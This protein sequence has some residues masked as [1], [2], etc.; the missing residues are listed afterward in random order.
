MPAA[1]LRSVAQPERQPQVVIVGAGFGGLSAARALCGKGADVTIV[2][3]QN[4]HLFQPLLYQVATAGLSPADIAAPIRSV[5]K[6]HKATR[7]LLDEVTGV[8]A[9][10][11]LVLLADGAPLPYDYLVLATG[12]THSYF[13]RDDWAGVAPGLK[14]IDD[15]TRLRRNI[16][17]ALEHAE[18]L[19]AGPARDRQLTFVLVGGGPTGV[20]MAGAIAELCR[21]TVTAD[22]R[23]IMTDQARVILVQAAP[24]L[25]PS[26]PENLSECAR[27][28]L[29]KLG[30]EVLTDARV[31]DIDAEGVS[32]DDMRIEAGTVIWCA[33]VKASPVAD[34][35][36]IAAD[37]TGRVTVGPDLS[38]PEFPNVF[39]IGDAAMVAQPD[40]RSVPGLA[41]AAK[42]MGEHVARVIAAL[43]AGTASPGAFRYKDWGNLATI[44]RKRAVADFGFARMRGTLAWLLW[45]VAHIF[46]L[47]G[48][49]N[50][51]IV[52]AN[53]LWHYVTFDRG[54]RL[55]TGLDHRLKQ[56]KQPLS[57]PIEHGG[58]DV[59][60][61]IAS[62]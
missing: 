60:D 56:P 39:V 33:G 50:R 45:C 58:V 3:K 25:L 47:V 28:S 19:P 13:G 30:V 10:R 5:V 53:W 17:F 29:E 49:R 12:A 44:G 52:G 9:E 46:F 36:G 16:L 20:E 55:I 38:L 26:F 24:R 7:V 62:A 22:F 23:R 43:I 41:P 34:W 1:Q 2:D 40:G 61:R 27:R 35:L 14:T 59:R 8:D 21:H 15:A 51:L 48:F 42:Q 6:K 31:T 37:R 54:A 57:T 32:V 18:A 11:R 4:H